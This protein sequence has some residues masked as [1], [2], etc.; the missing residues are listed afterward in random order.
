VK[1]VLNIPKSMT[2]VGYFCMGFVEQFASEPELESIGWERRLSLEDVLRHETF[3]QE[4]S[5]TRR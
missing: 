2:L 1:A 5:A 4:W 3:D